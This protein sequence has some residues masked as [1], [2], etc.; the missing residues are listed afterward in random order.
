MPR[1]QFTDSAERD[2][3]EI[4]T[5]IARDNPSYAACVKNSRGE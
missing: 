3:V 4:G 5:F 1:L 2:L